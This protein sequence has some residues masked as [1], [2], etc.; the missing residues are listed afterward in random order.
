ML[1]ISHVIV[2]HQP[3]VLVMS[4]SCLYI[5]AK[6]SMT[7]DMCV[8]IDIP[9]LVRIDGK[10]Y[11]SACSV[12]RHAASSCTSTS[13]SC[14]L[15]K[16]R[17]PAPWCLVGR[18][19]H[20]QDHWRNYDVVFDC[21]SPLCIRASIIRTKPDSYRLFQPR[22]YM[23][24]HATGLDLFLTCSTHGHQALSYVTLFSTLC[25]PYGGHRPHHKFQTGVFLLAV[26]PYVEV[27]RSV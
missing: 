19:A 23:A 12:S 20:F 16:A 21:V 15:C 9:F 10:G 5:T 27:R 17:T 24:K 18:Q 3:Y 13:M 4:L 1:I 8:V 22:V 2:T 11:R 7:S 25:F 14:C 6:P 26:V